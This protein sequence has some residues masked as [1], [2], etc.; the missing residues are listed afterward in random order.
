MEASYHWRTLLHEVPNGESRRWSLVV[1]PS[2]VLIDARHRQSYLRTAERVI[3]PETYS[4]LRA[5]T[6]YPYLRTDMPF[7]TAPGR[8]EI[9][10]ELRRGAGAYYGFLLAEVTDV[11]LSGTEASLRE[12]LP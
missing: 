4:Q 12:W 1:E 11:R 9:E 2:T 10:I 6:G 3:Q 7:Y 5:I 8:L